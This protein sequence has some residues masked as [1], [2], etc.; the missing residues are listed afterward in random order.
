[1]LFKIVVGS[2]IAAVKILQEDDRHGW[3]DGY[4]I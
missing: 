2:K 1:M 4:Y 3:R